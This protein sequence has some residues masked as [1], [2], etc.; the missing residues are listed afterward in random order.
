ER[1]HGDRLTLEMDN[2]MPVLGVGFTISN[3]PDEARV[4]TILPTFRT[5]GFLTQFNDLDEEGVKVVIVSLKGKA[6]SPGAG[7]VLE[8]FYENSRGLF[9]RFFQNRNM[10]PQLTG[11]NVAD[12]NNQP[13]AVNT[14]DLNL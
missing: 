14:E 10:D 3:L 12:A 13:V 7:S 9:Q 2:N 8:I 11:I 5:N 4:K 6:I 1:N